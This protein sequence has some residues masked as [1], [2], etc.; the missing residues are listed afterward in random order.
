RARVRSLIANQRV[1]AWDPSELPYGVGDLVPGAG[2]GRAPRAEQALADIGLTGC[3]AA[4]AETGSLAMISAPGRSRVVS[5]LPP[6]HIAIVAP[7]ELTFS[8]AEFFADR[9]DLLGRAASCTF[10]T[11]PSRTADI[12]LTLT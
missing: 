5:L 10:I 1:L 7:T 6:A 9:A 8:M 3:D 2:L 12:E 4:I 11:G